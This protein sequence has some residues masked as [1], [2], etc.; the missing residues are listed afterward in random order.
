M[1]RLSLLLALLLASSAAAIALDPRQAEDHGDLTPDHVHHGEEQLGEMDM[2]GDLSAAQP[3]AA[4][5]S[6]HGHHHNS[7][8]AP[9]L[10]LNETEILLTHA[11]DP[12]SYFDY[13]RQTDQG[14]RYSGLLIAHVVCMVLAFCFVLPTGQCTVP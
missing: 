1:A 5:A 12:L 14:P 6:A 4:P 9:L 11:P 10:E 3:A 2:A 8:A 13:D 7:H